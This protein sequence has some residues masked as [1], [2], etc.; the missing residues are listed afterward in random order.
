MRG[1]HAHAAGGE[2]LIHLSDQFDARRPLR[3]TNP[4]AGSDTERAKGR[5]EHLA[6]LCDRSVALI[7]AAIGLQDKRR[8]GASPFVF[9]SPQSNDA[10]IEPAATPLALPDKKKGSSRAQRQPA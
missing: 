3:N 7:E 9:P 10:P 5:V 1:R 6:P 8:K 2:V 4:V